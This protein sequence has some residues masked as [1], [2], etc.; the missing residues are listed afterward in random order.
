MGRTANATLGSRIPSSASANISLPFLAEMYY[1]KSTRC[2]FSLE[3]EPSACSFFS[4]HQ[5]TPFEMLPVVHEFHSYF[6]FDGTRI[7]IPCSAGETFLLEVR[8]DIKEIKAKTD[9]WLDGLHLK[10]RIKG[11]KCTKETYMCEYFQIF[12]VG[13]K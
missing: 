10:G 12:K 11:D 4:L 3:R 1:E 13:R 7:Q 2:I 8:Q 6:S 9:W 5:T